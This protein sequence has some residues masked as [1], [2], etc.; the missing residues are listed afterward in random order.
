MLLSGGNKEAIREKFNLKN[1]KK[2]NQEEINQEINKEI[3]QEINQELNEEN[4]I[5]G[6]RKKKI[7]REKFK[8]IIDKKIDEIDEIYTVDNMN[9]DNMNVDNSESI[10]KKI[11]KQIPVAEEISAYL[12]NLNSFIE[13]EYN[14]THKKYIYD[15]KLEKGFPNGKQKFKFII[16]Q[17]NNFNTLP[18]LTYLL[19]KKNTKEDKEE[20]LILTEIET[21]NIK[22]KS[23]EIVDNII[24]ENYKEKP[25]YKGYKEY[26]NQF[27]LFFEHSPKEEQLIENI[28]RKNRWFWA[29]VYEL[30]NTKKVLNFP[31]QEDVIEFF[32]NNLNITQIYTEDNVTTYE[33]P[34]I[35]YHGSHYKK[36]NFVAI[37]G[38]TRASSE[39]S[40]GPFYYFGPYDNAVRYSMFTISKK[41]MIIGGKSITVDEEGR[42]DKGGL[43]R[44]VIFLG[45]NKIF[46]EEEG[47]IKKSIITNVKEAFIDW[48][49]N[50]NSA[51]TGLYN[52][53]IEGKP[54]TI[55]SKYVVKQY[56]QLIPLSY[57][58]IN[59]DTDETDFEKIKIE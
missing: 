12:P 41:P 43:V 55:Y 32:L 11:L 21:D 24:F 20:H 29:V 33:I 59:T 44:F 48:N 10:E 19:Y 45:K 8:K 23:K 31:I 22:K 46:N 40:L 25:K 35:A 30:V 9:V 54:V 3:N 16:Y 5:I 37:F 13:V 17:I 49:E 39:A 36:I 2:N 57:H 56:E 38:V 27:Y 1:N 6:G 7:K 15:I 34:I 50:Y 14:K 52:K 58:Y 26:K 47:F 51:F 18:F 53:I 42:H 28:K 4:N